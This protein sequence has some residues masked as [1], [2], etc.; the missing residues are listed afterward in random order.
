[1]PARPLDFHNFPFPMVGGLDTKID[2]VALPAPKLQLCENAYSDKSGTLKRRPGMSI[3]GNALLSGSSIGTPIALSSYKDNQIAFSNNNAY[4]YGSVKGGWIDKGTAYSMRVRV[5]NVVNSNASFSANGSIDMATVGNI[6]VVANMV[7]SPSGA[8]TTS[9][10]LVSVFDADGTV[11]KSGKQLYTVTA[12]AAE[13][14][15]VRCIALGVRIY[16]FYYDSSAADLMVWILDT[17]SASTVNTALGAS[18]VSCVTNINTTTPIYD[19]AVTSTSADVHI[20]YRNTGAAPAQ[21][22]LGFVD[23]SGAL[24]STTTHNATGT[25]VGLAV[26]V[27]SNATT[28]GFCY[29]TNTTPTDLYAVIKSFS[30]GSWSNVQTSGAIEAGLTAALYFACLGCLWENT[31]TFRMFYSG[32]G[33]GANNQTYQRTYTTAGAASARLQTLRHSFLASKP[34]TGTDGNFYFWSFAG[35]LLTVIQPTLFLMRHDGIP[36]A[37]ANQDVACFPFLG[38]LPQVQSSGTGTFTVAT[39]YLAHIGTNSPSSSFI[40]DGT[41]L[42]SRTIAV[43]MTHAQ[44]HKTVEVGE[45]L[46]MAG[47]FLQ[48]YDGSGFTEAGFLRIASVAGTTGEAITVGGGAGAPCAYIVVPEMTNTR[49]EREQGTHNGSITGVIGDTVTIPTTPF[50]LHKSPRPNFVWAVYRTG[51]NPTSDT[52]FHRLGEVENDPTS[53][54]VTFLNATADVTDHEPFYQDSG[55]LENIAPQSGYILAQG[56]GRVFVAGCSDDPHRIEAS[57]IR[58]PDVANSLTCFTDTS[59]IHVPEAGGAITAMEYLNEQLVIFKEAKI[60]VLP[61]GGGPNGETGPNKLG[62]GAFIIPE[63]IQGADTGCTGQRSVLSTPLG[64]MFQG[65]KGIELLDTGQQVHYIGDKLEGFTVGTINGAVLMPTFQQARFSSTSA[66]YVF[67]YYNKIWSTFS[68]ASA[69]GAAAIVLAQ[70]GKFCSIGTGTNAGL[71]L[72]EDTSDFSSDAG[73]TYIMKVRLAWVASQEARQ[74]SLRFRWLGLVITPRDVNAG[75]NVKVSVNYQTAVTQT[76]ALSFVVGEVNLPTRRQIR[77]NAS[78][79]I[80]NS[81]QIEIDD[82]GGANAGLVLHQLDFNMA[83]RDTHLGRLAD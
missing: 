46:Y 30:A 3:L 22:T 37:W 7:F 41:Q 2:G 73:V 27:A 82:G 34:F 15:A 21:F 39:P 80:A 1:M 54:T 6:T 67:D 48:Q 50:T 5:N 20:V 24:V 28:Y 33:T 26:A 9:Q 61:R 32:D 51:A 74:G 68:S 70:G 35:A 31:T 52:P 57:K 45:T 29:T 53:N 43:D 23:T 11:Y 13:P 44:S 77:I 18:A 78:S 38:Y 72:I 55:E 71:I 40:G 10:V 56:G 59:V 81:M 42:G 75:A 62:A 36:V 60:Y 12:A 58:D 79:Q 76:V 65:I 25:P 16:V 83:L 63:L 47:G 4:E 17:S 14:T 19:V 69:P 49:G 64:L 66:I 8:N